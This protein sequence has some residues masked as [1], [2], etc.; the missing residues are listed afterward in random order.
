MPAQ[1]LDGK[2]ISQDIIQQV[3]AQVDARV[4][5]G[6]RAPAWRW[7]WWAATRRRRFMWAIKKASVY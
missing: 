1:I 2:V 6:K 4:A 7:C 3:R 5:S